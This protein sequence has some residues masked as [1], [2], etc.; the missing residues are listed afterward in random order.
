MNAKAEQLLAAALSLSETDRADLANALLNSLQAATSNDEPMAPEVQ[1]AWADV[2]RRRVD[3]LEAGR[4]STVS[5]DTVHQELLES[6]G[7]R[8]T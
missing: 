7:R 1:A 5:W 6:I 2:I 8:G 4:A 3:D